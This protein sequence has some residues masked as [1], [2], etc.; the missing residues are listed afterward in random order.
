MLVCVHGFGNH[1]NSA[2]GVGCL[3]KYANELDTIIFTYDQEG[4]GYSGG[5]RGVVH[6]HAHLVD[7]L[8]DL[9]H[10][11][12]SPNPVSSLGPAEILAQVPGRE[13]ILCGESIGGGVALAGCVRLQSSAHVPS[14]LL[15]FA[16]FLQAQVP[17]GASKAFVSTVR[18]MPQMM[19]N[20][21]LPQALVP[22]LKGEKLAWVQKP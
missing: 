11:L 4:H 16:P 21:N 17:F 6:D 12:C 2:R 15:L 19:R 8:V 22:E 14:A 3:Q 10:M 5:Q 1:C 18:S 20:A 7:D 13:L 9:V